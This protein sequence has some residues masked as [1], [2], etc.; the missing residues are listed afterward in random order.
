MQKN[1]VLDTNVLIHSDGT[2]LT[3]FEENNIWIPT[4]VT[5]E[6]DNLK[7]RK[8]KPETAY[9]ARASIRALK[10]LSK[11][12][13]L[14]TGVP[15][16]DGGKLFLL[17]EENLNMA[18]PAGWNSS[19]P[20]NMILMMTKALSERP[21]MKNVVLITNDGNVQLKAITLGIPVEEYR[22]DR[23]DLSTLYTGRTVRHVTD[24]VM[25]EFAASCNREMT[26]DEKEQYM[27][28]MA[29]SRKAEKEGYPS[30]ISDAIDK[31]LTMDM[32]NSAT[33]D[34]SASPYDSQ[35]SYRTAL[36]LDNLARD[37]AEAIDAADAREDEE[38]LAMKEDPMVEDVNREYLKRTDA[39][40]K[41]K[42]KKRQKEESFVQDIRMPDK[43]PR[44]IAVDG[45]TFYEG[46]DDLQENEYVH[47][48]PWTNSAGF[49]TQYKNG[50]LTEL[51]HQDDPIFGLTMLNEGQRFLKEALMKSCDEAPLVCVSGPAGTGKTLVALAAGLEQA[52][53]Q[54]I[55]DQVLLCR[56]NIMAGGKDENIGFL[57][58]TEQEKISP[59]FRGAEDAI[60]LLFPYQK[61]DSIL[62][63]LMDRGVL[64]MQAVA[65]LRGRSI[66]N[67]FIILDEAQ[68]MTPNLML[69]LLSRLGAGSKIVC[70]GDPDQVDNPHLSMRNNGLVYTIDRM[71][72]SSLCEVITFEE[73]ECKRSPLAKEVAQRMKL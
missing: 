21:G 36:S 73:T 4:V 51:H 37:S 54:S 58:G 22:N 66:A 11:K 49:L 3:K 35:D 40:Q 27:A 68:N 65:Y 29:A 72:G 14:L 60:R 71:K 10:E 59:L 47:L 55:Y 70:L 19:K 64:N 39:K 52:Y 45:S 1:F 67:S 20:D 48:L 50:H 6:L 24:A 7:E 42:D 38:I 28:K 12:G 44:R 31:A 43:L 61:P 46:L 26:P 30:D 2:A 56:A 5:E 17:V 32:E 15:T 41:K 16:Q 53:N 63:E 62:A 69:M 25:T 57:P 13:N 23:V 8:D 9:A 18:L 33:L 34:F